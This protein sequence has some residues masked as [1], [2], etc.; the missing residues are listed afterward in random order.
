MSVYQVTFKR[1]KIVLCTL[2]STFV[3]SELSKYNLIITEEIIVTVN[4]PITISQE[5]EIIVQS[6]TISDSLK[7]AIPNIENLII[8]SISKLPKIMPGY[9]KIEETGELIPVTT[10][11]IIPIKISE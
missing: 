7:I 8:E 6:F 11:F 10:K 3:S 2:F 5:G 4:I 1:K 9:K